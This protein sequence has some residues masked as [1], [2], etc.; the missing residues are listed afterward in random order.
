[1]M[2]TISASHPLYLLPLLASLTQIPSIGAEQTFNYEQNMEEVASPRRCS[3]CASLDSVPVDLLMKKKMFIP[4]FNSKEDVACKR[5]H[6]AATLFQRQLSYL[7]SPKCN[8]H[9]H[10]RPRAMENGFGATMMSL[11]KPTM[12][13]LTYGYCIDKPAQFKMWSSKKCAGWECFFAEVGQP[14]ITGSADL[15][16]AKE[17]QAHHISATSFLSERLDDKADCIPWWEVQYDTDDDKN[18]PLQEM[19]AVQFSHKLLGD[20][21]LPPA[22]QTKGHFFTV[23]QITAG[24]FELA[25]SVQKRIEDKKQRL[26][27]PK[28]SPLIGLHVRLGDACIKSEHGI[29][30]HGRKCNQLVDFMQHVRK[31]SNEYSIKNIYLATDSEGVLNDTRQYPQYNWF[32]DRTTRRGGVLDR[33]SIEYSLSHKLID[34]YDEGLGVID[35]VF[36]LAET[37]ALIGKFTSNIDRVAYQLMTGQSNCYKPYVSLDSTWCFDHGLKSGHSDFGPFWC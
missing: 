27:W 8:L 19:C 30:E 24:L 20:G 17:G 28:N 22:F 25:P 29:G 15:L 1:M 32:F 3:V 37:H 21:V 35:D 23:S 9:R 5:E 33:K 13:A 4:K 18:A 10:F 16:A 12:H 11:V 14:N 26:G 36:L 7:K 34:G 6:P 31:I 2:A